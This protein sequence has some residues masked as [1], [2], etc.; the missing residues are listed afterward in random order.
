M[1]LLRYTQIYTFF[2]FDMLAAAVEEMNRYDESLVDV[3]N[4]LN[5]SPESSGADTYDLFIEYRG[6]RFLFYSDYRGFSP[7]TFDY[8]VEI[9]DDDDFTKFF[10]DYPEFENPIMSIADQNNGYIE[11]TYRD[12]VNYDQAKNTF[13]YRSK[14]SRDEIFMTV[15]RKE[16]LPDFDYSSLFR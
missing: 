2:N 12:L 15:K 5:I 9:K 7:N 10:K 16:T 14:T 3:L 6:K 4:V 1:M 13:T 8:S 11:F